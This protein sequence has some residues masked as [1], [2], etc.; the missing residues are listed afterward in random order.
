MRDDQSDVP[1]IM[2]ATEIRRKHQA[3]LARRRAK[4]LDEIKDEISKELH[5][6]NVTI[7]LER[8]RHKAAIDALLDELKRLGGTNETTGGKQHD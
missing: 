2:M 1:N 6:H 4:A 3:T 5:R 7:D 8:Q